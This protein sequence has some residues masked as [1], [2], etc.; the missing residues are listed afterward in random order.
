[1]AFDAFTL[2][3]RVSEDRLS[4]LVDCTVRHRILPML[5]NAIASQL[6]EKGV[7]PLP[8]INEI[9]VQLV[10]AARQDRNVK[11]LVIVEGVAPIPS[12]DGTIEWAGD[13][14]TPGYYVDEKTGTMDYRRPNGRPT[15]TR[16][17]LLAQF[18]PPRQGRAGHDVFGNEIPVS[19]PESFMPR[20][21]PKVTARHVDEGTQFFSEAD[22][23]AKW[24]G[25]TLS[26]DEML[27]VEGNVGLETGNIHHPKRV[28]IHGDVLEDSRVEAGDTIEIDGIVQGAELITQGDLIIGG[29]ILGSSGGA[30][31]RSKGCVQAKYVIDV[32]I[33][34]QGDVVVA[35]EITNAIVKTTGAVKV[36]EG[37]IVGGR[38]I[39]LGG[40]E[41]GE[42][43]STGLQPTHL[44][45]A[46]N[47]RILDKLTPLR[48]RIASFEKSYGMLHK[49]LMRY[50]AQ[51]RQLS[52]KTKEKAL[53]LAGRTDKLKEALKRLRME[54]EELERPS[55]DRANP[56]IEIKTKLNSDTVLQIGQKT[57][58]IHE[59]L[60]GPLRAY[61]M[62]GRICLSGRYGPVK[63]KPDDSK[64]EAAEGEN[65]A[66]SR[67]ESVALPRE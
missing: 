27:V 33:E 47:Y 32:T 55:R 29:G 25:D 35:N 48:R 54:V 64:P 9:T 18:T 14:F 43:G 21:G 45:A 13:F 49:K 17:Q 30:A 42:S 20:A 66:Q 61:V 6:K 23:R 46:E 65:A 44:L 3:V 4:A 11:D 2:Q 58:P 41:V 62:D 53:K 51:R 31:I 63:L 26:V 7:T 1:M 50:Y 19:E 40:I 37:R 67:A 39:A 15:V 28:V 10:Q 36:P 12:R 5:T 57:L 59:T 8:S 16:G 22:G 38:I 52:E 56:V 34:A 24:N 60:D